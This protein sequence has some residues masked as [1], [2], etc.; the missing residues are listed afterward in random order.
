[1]RID[2][3]EIP[4]SSTKLLGSHLLVHGDSIS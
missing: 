1:L 4:Q 3:E 2:M